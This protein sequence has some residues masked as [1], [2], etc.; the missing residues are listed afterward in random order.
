MLTHILIRQHCI[1]FM[2]P[3]VYHAM[4]KWYKSTISTSVSTLGQW[5]SIAYVMG[6]GFFLNSCIAIIKNSQKDLRK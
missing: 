5:L 2:L 1:S 4:S 6:V 3:L